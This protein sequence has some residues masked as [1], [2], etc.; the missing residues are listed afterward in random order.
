M[1]GHQHESFKQLNSSS[2]ED[3]QSI[4]DT[5]SSDSMYDCSNIDSKNTKP[6]VSGHNEKFLTEVVTKVT[7]SDSSNG[8]AYN[9]EK[10]VMTGGIHSI[11]IRNKNTQE[12]HVDK[13]KIHV[14]MK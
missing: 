3:T 4:S 2:S 8:S 12:K 10:K 1:E 5:E 13:P 6:N 11:V 7:D 14:R 9:S